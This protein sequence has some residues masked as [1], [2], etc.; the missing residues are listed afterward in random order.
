MNILLVEPRTPETFWSL[1]HALRFVGKCAANPPLGL[2]TVAGMLPR[3]WSCR[4]S[5]LNCS[6]LRDEDIRWADW[7]LVSGMEIHRTSVAEIV[8]RCHAL[9]TMVI[10]GGPLFNSDP[11]NNLEVDHVVVGEAEELAAALVA[12]L[13]SGCPAPIYEA[14]R[15]PDLSLTPVPRWDLLDLS[16]YATLSVQSCRGCPFDC[17]FCDVVALNGHKPRHKSPEQFVAE[18]E[19]LRILGW[20][21]PVFVV[22]DNFI[23]DQRRCREIL[24]AII[25]WR[26]QTRARMVFITEASVNMA[27]HPDLL[28]LM[29]AAGFKK[30]F[31]GLETPSEESLREC[32]KF[33]NLKEDPTASV[34]AIQT[35]GLEV[36][37]GFIVGFDSDE[38]DIFQRQFDFIQ[39]AGVVTAMVGL[40]QA[41]PRSRLYQR[42]FQ[43]GRLLGGS[44]GDNTLGKFNFQTRLD[45][46]FLEENYRKLMQRLY[47]PGNYYRRVLTFLAAHRNVGPPERVSWRDLGAVFKTFWVMGLMTKGRRA[48]W[49]FLTTALVRHPGQIG[50]ALTMVIMGHHYR[51]VA[52]SL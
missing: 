33:Q 24:H 52:A 50:L 42:L 26:R 23:G 39:N 29:V 11:E 14:P 30:V 10:G 35:A 38:P 36:M 13:E 12:D 48:Y 37:G 49:R 27:A 15:F 8:Q 3:Q 4:L 47:E 5:D 46:G 7:V 41:L 45:T 2:L 9:E 20:K 21:G 34:R 31:L 28:E 43:E 18:L 22:D 25:D 1:R 6:S 51:R 32:R 40:L 16:R 44:L 17:E 19:S